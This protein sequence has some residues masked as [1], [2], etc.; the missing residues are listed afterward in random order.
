MSWLLT[1]YFFENKK[2]NVNFLL[3]AFIFIIIILGSIIKYFN[4]KKKPKLKIKREYN[5]IEITLLIFCGYL[6]M[7]NYTIYGLWD[8][9]FRVIKQSIIVG[10]MFVWTFLLEMFLSKRI[11]RIIFIPIFCFYPIQFLTGEKNLMIYGA[12]ISAVLLVEIFYYSLELF[13]N[14]NFNYIKTEII[15]TL[16]KILFPI[17]II[18]TI[19]FFTIGYQKFSSYINGIYI[20]KNHLLYLIIPFLIFILLNLFSLNLKINALL[21]FIANSLNSFFLKEFTILTLYNETNFIFTTIQI[22]FHDS[23][24]LYLSIIM[25]AFIAVGITFAIKFVYLE[26]KIFNIKFKFLNNLKRKI[27]RIKSIKSYELKFLIL[28]ISFYKSLNLIDNKINV[29]FLSKTNSKYLLNLLY[30]YLLISNLKN[31]L[32]YLLPLNYIVFFLISIFSFKFVDKFKIISYT[33]SSFWSLYLTIIF[34]LILIFWDRFQNI[35]LSHWVK[36]EDKNNLL[37][38]EKEIQQVKNKYNTKKH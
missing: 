16:F 1:I 7:S 28:K 15:I 37:E 29:I 23:V 26:W 21:L 4:H 10:F 24:E 13:K 31:C 18:S 32:S 20:L 27:Q 2:D 33:L 8:L 11:L 17:F 6:M 3:C 35:Y 34:T 14:K 22:Y 30:K 5:L 9:I 19:M 38:M 25:K 12:L 36:T